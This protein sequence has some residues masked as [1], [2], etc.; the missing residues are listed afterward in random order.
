MGV[1]GG[2]GV[3]SGNGV[4]MGIVEGDGGDGIKRSIA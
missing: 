4:V 2:D 1:K 3:T